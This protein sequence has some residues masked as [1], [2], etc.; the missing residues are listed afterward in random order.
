MTSDI[1]GCTC[2][3][4]TG[5]IGCRSPPVTVSTIR[6]NTI[7]L[8]GIKDEDLIFFSHSNVA[9]SHLPYMVALE[10]WPPAHPIS[11]CNVP[12]MLAIAAIPVLQMYTKLFGKSFQF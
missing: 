1:A 2:R 5:C 7:A 4:K 10:R 12:C 11:L 9:L 3:K 8:S 6:E